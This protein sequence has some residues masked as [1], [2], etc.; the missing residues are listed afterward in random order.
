MPQGK[1]RCTANRE[2]IGAQSAAILRSGL[3]F[4][5]FGA[6]MRRENGSAVA[7]EI[8]WCKALRKK[9]TAARPEK[10]RD[11]KRPEPG[12]KFSI[13]PGQKNA[14][15]P[16]KKQVSHPCLYLCG[17]RRDMFVVLALSL[18]YPTQVKPQPDAIRKFL[19]R[20]NG[21]ANVIVSPDFKAAV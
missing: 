5:G 17:V 3:N 10:S 7:V 9:I 13:L 11:E 16:P 19:R 14:V 8:I 4:A 15:L 18:A 21:K 12:E 20:F 1:N 6:Q 2:K